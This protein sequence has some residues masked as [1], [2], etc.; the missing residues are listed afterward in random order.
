[1]TDVFGLSKWD[2]WNKKIFSFGITNF[3][4]ILELQL[5]DRAFPFMNDCTQPELFVF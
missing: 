3:H 1:M 4:K 5:F 2:L